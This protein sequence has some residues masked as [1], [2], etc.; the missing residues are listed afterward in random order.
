VSF[1]LWPPHRAAMLL[2]AVSLL[3]VG[4][5][6]AGAR[7]PAPPRPPSADSPP[8]RGSSGEPPAARIDRRAME[9]VNTAEPHRGRATARAP[10]ARRG[11][12]RSRVAPRSRR[13]SAVAAAS[14]SCTTD[15]VG[16]YKCYTW[17]ERYGPVQ[18]GGWSWY[19]DRYRVASLWGVIWEEW[20]WYYW[21]GYRWVFHSAVRA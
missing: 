17:L 20:H 9:P 13:V 6:D 16:V 15:A 4:V 18:S 21:N 19:A 7:T 14:A 5:A 2:T 10:K 1:S 12:S 11:V 8:N 3:A